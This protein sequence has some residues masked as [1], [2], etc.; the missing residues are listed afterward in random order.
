MFNK[1]RGH[2]KENG[3]EGR[4]VYSSKKRRGDW[5]TCSLHHGKKG[6][7]EKATYFF[8]GGISL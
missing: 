1:E 2:C 6:K 5:S 3:R 7:G 8:K 4:N